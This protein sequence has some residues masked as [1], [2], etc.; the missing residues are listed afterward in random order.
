MSASSFF[1]MRSKRLKSV[2][3]LDLIPVT[4]VD[5]EV[6]VDGKVHLIIPR[7]NYK[8]FQKIF[9]GTRISKVFK[10]LLDEPG[11]HV[12]L[13][14]NGENTVEAISKEMTEHYSK[15]HI[16][17]ENVEDR[18]SKF[19]EQLYNEG[20]ISFSNLRKRD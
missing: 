3:V 16:E 20:C 1:W 5:H 7:F 4:I 17:F 6:A 13:R 9:T 11:S 8:F 14:I 15:N 2:N 19:I 12:W 18:V 10:L